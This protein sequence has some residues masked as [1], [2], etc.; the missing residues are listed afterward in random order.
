MLMQKAPFD[1]KLLIVDDAST[2][3]SYEIA[4]RYEQ[5]NPTKIE[6]VRNER[7]LKI[8]RATMVGYTYLKGVEYFCLLDAD[9][10]YVDECFFANAVKWLDKHPR[11]AIYMG[12]LLVHN[13]KGEESRYCPVD[14]SEADFDYEDHK[15]GRYIS[16]Q[17]TG[18]L[19]R[20]IYM[21]DGNMK[22]M[23]RALAMEYPGVF[24]AETFRNEWHLKGG[25]AHFANRIVGVYNYTGSGTWSGLSLARQ[26]MSVVMW[27]YSYGRFFP[28]EQ[29]YYFRMARYAFHDLVSEPELLDEE[30]FERHR[31][32]MSRIFL[33]L[34]PQEPAPRPRLK[35]RLVK[36]AIKLIPIAKWRRQLRRRYRPLS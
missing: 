27:N 2:D 14:L 22:D 10:Y 28:D 15:Y 1:Y 20:N 30:F 31:E 13:D 9:D 19:Y 24:C 36:M 35:E 4:R 33:A 3:G 26:R 21:I 5:Q 23:E 11:W 34:Y 6:V 25:K 8:L 16:M 17:T 29:D 32:N 18:C 12:N 7:N